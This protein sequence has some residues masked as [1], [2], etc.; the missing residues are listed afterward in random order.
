MLHRAGRLEKPPALI[1]GSLAYDMAGVGGAMGSLLALWQRLRDGSGQHI[2]VSAMDATAGLSDWS[3]PNYSLNPA[4]G[5]RAGSGIYTLYRCADGYIRMIILVPKHWRALK[6]WVGNPVELDDPKYDQFIN[7][8]I[9]LDKIVAVLERFFADKNKVEVAI[10]AQNRGIPATPLL[11]PSEVLES[12][13]TVGRG[14]FCTLPLG[15]KLEGKIPSGF[16]TIDGERAGPRTGPPEPGEFG[17]ASWSDS[18]AR[19]AFEGM[20]GASAPHPTTPPPCTGSG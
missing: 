13:H 10:E 14:T 8:L 15:P 5:H 2:D 9:E 11:R 3:I 1:P 12:E 20:L 17:D 16:V 7:R 18:D 19:A 6:K 4:L